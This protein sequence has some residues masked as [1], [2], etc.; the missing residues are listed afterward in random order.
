M[1]RSSLRQRKYDYL[2][3]QGFYPSEAKELSRTSRQG[4]KAPYFARMIRSRRRT[5][6]NL[7]RAG[8]SDRDIRDYIKNQYINNGW[9]KK[10]KLG[11]TLINIWGLLRSHEDKARDI[12]D[13]YES[14]WKK[15]TYKRSTAKK[16]HKRTTRR[17]MLRSLITK[18]ENRISRTA[19]VNRREALE[20]QLYGYQQQL[21]RL[22]S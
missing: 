4:M 5:I 16:E 7:K 17:D 21:R 11:R 13:E 20:E 10:D 2:L 3:R 1:F 9:L 14:P 6:D 18:L 15:R 22:E 8:K 12:G 19:N